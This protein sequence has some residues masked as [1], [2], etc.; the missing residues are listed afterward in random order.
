MKKKLDDRLKNNWPIE[1]N[2]ILVNILTD[3]RNGTLDYS[4]QFFL[5]NVSPL[6]AKTD[7]NK[8][9]NDC[10]KGQQILFNMVWVLFYTFWCCLCS[11]N[12]NG[13]WQLCGWNFRALNVFLYP[14][15]WQFSLWETFMAWI[16][17][18]WHSVIW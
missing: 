7:C 11:T 16:R 4:F 8:R 6:K 2:E 13:F 12:Y 5:M 3:F 10:Q 14:I 17:A 9:Q 18:Q 15:L 1:D